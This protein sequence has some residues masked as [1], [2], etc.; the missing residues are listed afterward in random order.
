VNKIICTLVTASV[1]VGGYAYGQ[2]KPKTQDK[3]GKQA[4]RDSQ[5][6]NLTAAGD[7][8]IAANNSTVT[9]SST[10]AVSLAGSTLSSA[11]GINIVSSADAAVANGVNVYDS[12]LTTDAS[13]KGA[14]VNQVNAIGQS[15]TATGTLSG[16]KRGANSQYSDTESSD[17]TKANSSSSSLDTSLN[18]STTDSKS[19]TD[20]SSKTHTS[21]AS[22]STSKNSAQQASASK[23]SSLNV[24]ASAANNSSN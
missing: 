20:D 19:F 6:D 11:S 1:L 9:S 16:Y 21:S 10:G 14:D 5:M 4:L 7:P 24:S 18:H 8:S 22:F 3:Q 13:T 12:S 23:S 15:I 2:N 17:V